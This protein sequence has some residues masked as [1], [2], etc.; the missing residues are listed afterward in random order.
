M[1]LTEK[2]AVEAVLTFD[3]FDLR[4]EIKTQLQAQ[5]FT[6]PTSIQAKAFEL[7]L[8]SEHVHVHGQA[9][10]GTGKTL[11]FG[12]PIMQRID[13]NQ[14]ITQALII[15]PTRELAV[16]IC[17]S[18]SPFTKVLGV[19]IRAI[20]GGVSIEEQCSALKRGLQIVVGTPGRVNDLLK[21]KKLNISELKTLV[22]DEADI[23]LDM[24]F[25]E[26]VDEILRYTNSNREIWLF[27]ATVKDAVQR[28]LDQYAPNA[29]SLRISRQNIANTSIKQHYCIIPSRDRV[30]AL[31]RFI[32]SAPEFYG[33]VFCQTKIL[34]SEVADR[35]ISLG[36]RV[37]ALHGDMSQVQRDSVV[38][39]FRSRE[40]SVL[41]ATDVAGR[42]ID[43]QDVT[44][45][46]NFSL[47]EDYESYIHRTGRTGRA[48]KEG[49]AITFINHGDV[50]AI[51]IIERK[52]RITLTPL[53]L[54]TQDDIIQGR[55]GKL[56][57]YLQNMSIEQC[58]QDVHQNISSLF[59]DY[60]Q[61]QLQSL[62]VN[63]VYDKFLKP[64]LSMPAPTIGRSSHGDRDRYEDNGRNSNTQ[65][66]T[67]PVGSDDGVTQEEIIEQ[68]VTNEVL[69]AE[70]ILKIRVIKRRTFIHVSPELGR[71]IVDAAKRLT[72]GGR[73]V[74]LF[75]AASQ[76]SRGGSSSQGRSSGSG[77]SGRSSN[78]GG[79]YD[80]ARS[81][82]GYADRGERGGSD[83]GDRSRSYSR[84]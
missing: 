46:I 23:M 30:S 78:G 56:T 7:L 70:D 80:R 39:K 82:T 6:T 5:G 10:T 24:G 67:L 64:V 38:R 65:E 45:V 17:E 62:M 69:T 59:V 44:H 68:L 4:P 49:I 43:I 74:S 3:Q 51:K 11:A 71:T 14:K 9:Q 2:E 60:S 16:Q 18:L 12:L 84:R 32:E 25:R 41:V 76:Q 26:E 42:G 31:C 20:Y 33:F 8:G 57:E 29:Q 35:L 36:Y 63:M 22:L 13:V 53:S 28:L 52:F 48:G 66:L 21:R 77:S 15:A 1:Q 19:S 58:Q 72:I 27:S 83:R 55:L 37:G 40:Y 81:S 61:E 50:R 73:K 34:T 79:R 75:P 54:P 47:P